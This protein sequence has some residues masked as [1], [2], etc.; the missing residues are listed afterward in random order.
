M[1]KPVIGK[2]FKSKNYIGYRFIV[3]QTENG[4]VHYDAY[5]YDGNYYGPG[6][7]TPK[8][9]LMWA[10]REATPEEIEALP[11]LAIAVATYRAEHPY[12]WS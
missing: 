3:G 4:D 8:S 5:G 9:I 7:C 1:P 2:V 6:W 12:P 10:E 11:L